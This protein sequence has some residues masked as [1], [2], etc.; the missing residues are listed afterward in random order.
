MDLWDLTRLLFRRWYVALP[1]LLVSLA[2]VAVISQTVPPDYSA[3]GHVTMIPPSQRTPAEN[4]TKIQNP[5]EELGFRALGQAVIIKLSEQKV[6]EDLVNAG[7][8]D[9]FT[10]GMD[11]R[12]PLFTIES[13]GSSAEQAIS[14]TRRVMKLIEEDVMA[15]Q[16]RYGVAGGDLITTLALD[17]GDTV[18]KITS[19]ATRV[20]LVATALGV[21]LSA[22]TT[23]A[24]DAILRRRS[25][26]RAPLDGAAPVL[27][28][29]DELKPMPKAKGKAK[30]V[31]QPDTNGA[32]P[33]EA[34]GIK[35]AKATAS[36][37]GVRAPVMVKYIDVD[38]METMNLDA[39]A[40]SHPEDATIVLPL[41]GA[42]RP[43]RDDKGRRD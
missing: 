17:N 11:D 16:T 36:V 6:L 18:V 39:A 4:P 30:I 19:K 40:A 25:R 21:L 3:T 35:P 32:K 31:K 28:A 43:G 41:Y 26:R 2:S 23:I 29:L 12:T 37:G 5:W 38:A 20:L 7:Y 8:T 15:R 13:I 14:T 33:A 22:A 1:M 34:N 24:I 42:K 27:D 9:N 10:V